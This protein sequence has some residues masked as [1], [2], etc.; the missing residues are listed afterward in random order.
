MNTSE[1]ELCTLEVPEKKIVF[2]GAD[3]KPLGS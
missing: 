1:D 2:F 3:G